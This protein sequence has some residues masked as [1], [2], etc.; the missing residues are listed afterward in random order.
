MPPK[1]GFIF[2]TF[3]L[4]PHEMTEEVH[5]ADDS[6][7]TEHCQDLS[8]NA[9]ALKSDRTWSANS[10]TTRVPMHVTTTLCLPEYYEI[11]CLQTTSVTVHSIARGTGATRDY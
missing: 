2:I 9:S 11:S 10:L 8:R 1:C 4:F 6:S 7:M 3:V 5:Q